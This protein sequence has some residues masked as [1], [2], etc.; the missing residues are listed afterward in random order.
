VNYDL[1]QIEKYTCLCTDSFTG[2]HCQFLKENVYITFVV[3]PNSTLKKNDAV[4][5]TVSYNDYDKETLR[6]NVR[7]QQVYDFLPEH[8]KLIYSYKL[9][10]YVPVTAILKVYGPNYYREEPN[11]YVLYFDPGE[12]EINITVDLTL[13]N[14][15]P[16]VQTLWHL[17][18]GI[19][20][21]GKLECLRH[22][23]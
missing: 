5:I 8:L 11:Y 17:V 21:S 19:Q 10:E 4:A 14:H 15:C 9:S 6:F 2:D 22:N 1:A 20:I 3:S 16:F 13:E 12:K 18:H 23:F 7:H